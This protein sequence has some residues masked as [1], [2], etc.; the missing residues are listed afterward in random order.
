MVGNYP[1][2]IDLENLTSI[3]GSTIELLLVNAD[4]PSDQLYL[5][6]DSIDSFGTTIIEN[7]V[8]IKPLIDAEC[9]NIYRQPSREDCIDYTQLSLKLTELNLILQPTDPRYSE[10][11]YVLYFGKDKEMN[12]GEED[13]E[14]KV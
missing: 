11:C 10:S 13:K 5:N 4:D 7:L 2:D 8:M 12:F 14:K 6:L 9:Y 1:A 3:H